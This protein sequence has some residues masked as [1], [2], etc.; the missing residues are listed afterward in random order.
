MDNDEFDSIDIMSIKDKKIKYIYSF[1]EKKY[2]DEISNKIL[3]IINNYNIEYTV[4]KNGIFINLNVIDDEIIYLIYDCIM[5]SN[6]CINNS[7]KNLIKMNTSVKDVKSEIEG[8]VYGT[9]TINYTKVDISY[10]ELS[11]RVLTI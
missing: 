5:S 7:T 2:S 11:R 10:L 4:N 9:D 8:F 6:K 3:T 1:F